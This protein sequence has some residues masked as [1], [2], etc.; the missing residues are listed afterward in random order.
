MP[1]SEPGSL[2]GQGDRNELREAHSL[3]IDGQTD[4]SVVGHRL[5]VMPRSW[6]YFR[7]LEAISGKMV[8]TSYLIRL[9]SSGRLLFYTQNLVFLSQTWVGKSR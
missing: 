5:A 7:L 9:E 8:N 1:K 4:P 6:L 3:F 2:S